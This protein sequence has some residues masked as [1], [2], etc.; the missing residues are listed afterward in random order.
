MKGV[1][2]SRWN[3]ERF[4][5]FQTVIMQQARRVTASVAICRRIKKRLDDWGE[6]KHAMLVNGTLQA[7]GE[8]LTVSRREETS[9]H[10]SQMYHSLVLCGKLRTAVRW[11]TETNTGGVLQPGDRCT[12][13]GDR[14]MEVLR[15]KHPEARTHKTANLDSY[16]GRPPELTP[17]DT[18]E[19]TVTEVARRLSGVAGPGGKD[20]VSL[21]HWLLGFGAAT[22]EH[23]LIVRDF[24]ELVGN[25]WPP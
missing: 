23:R 5:M 12:K 17:V 20:S 8:Y 16:P 24:V 14:V 18:T 22:A 21:H 25:G 9:E 19:D 7:C 6:G 3:S 4:I 2:E 15:K 13:T 10:Q 11:I 1:R